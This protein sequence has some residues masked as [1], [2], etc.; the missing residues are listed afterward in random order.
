M[1]HSWPFLLVLSTFFF[2]SFVWFSG[3]IINQRMRT[4]LYGSGTILQLVEVVDLTAL[5]KLAFA[6]ASIKKTIVSFN[7]W[8]GGNQ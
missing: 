1:Y 4:W 3:N 7:P 5:L 8:R 2:L 6:S